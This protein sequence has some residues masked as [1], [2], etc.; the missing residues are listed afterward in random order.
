[1]FNKHQ[2]HKSKVP[3]VLG[4]VFPTSDFPRLLNQAGH[5]LYALECI[6]DTEE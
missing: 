1:M 2:C 4:R 3:A 5:A 6:H